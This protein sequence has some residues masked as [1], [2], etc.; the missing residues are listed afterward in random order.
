[1][2]DSLAEKRCWICAILTGAFA[3]DGN[4]GQIHLLLST[5]GFGDFGRETGVHPAPEVLDVVEHVVGCGLG[6]ETVVWADDYGALGLCQLKD[7][8]TES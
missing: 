8:G 3:R 4:F 1:M 6:Q 2:V 5:G 7:P